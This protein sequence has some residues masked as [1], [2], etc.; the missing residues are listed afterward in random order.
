MVDGF[1]VVS[2]ELGTK[3]FVVTPLGVAGESGS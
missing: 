3:G 1:G 2:M